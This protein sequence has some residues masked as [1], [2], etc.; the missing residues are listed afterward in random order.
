[1]AFPLNPVDGS[2]LLQVIQDGRL[3]LVNRPQVQTILALAGIQSRP[4]PSLL[5]ERTGTETFRAIQGGN[6][7]E[8]ALSDLTA[9]LAGTATPGLV[10][11]FRAP[12]FFTGRE[13]FLIHQGSAIAAGDI[14]QTL[15]V[16][17]TGGSLQ[18]L[19][20]NFP[21]GGSGSI[22]ANALRNDQSGYVTTDDGSG[23]IL[24]DTDW[25]IQ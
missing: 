10:P 22:P 13:R 6:L 20:G 23:Y 18:G 14:S 19:G 1:M 9:Y 24:N 15:Y 17:G 5:T 25:I 4:N 16:R 12:D 3:V 21:D 7:V 2:E 11:T 8:M